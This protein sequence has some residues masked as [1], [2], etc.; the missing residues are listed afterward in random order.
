[1]RDAGSR[2]PDS[3]TDSPR[4]GQCGP[5]QL[6]RAA[7]H[8]AVSM[9]R[10]YTVPRHTGRSAANATSASNPAAH[11]RHGGQLRRGLRR[12]RGGRRSQRSSTG[13]SRCRSAA[14]AGTRPAPQGHGAAH[15]HAVHL[16]A[17][18]PNATS[19]P[20]PVHGGRQRGLVQGASGSAATSAGAR[21][22][23]QARVCAS[24]GAASSRAPLEPAAAQLPDSCS[25][26]SPGNTSLR[27]AQADA[28]ARQ[29]EPRAQ[30]AAGCR[31]PRSPPR[32]TG[33][34]PSAAAP[35]RHAAAAATRH[36]DRAGW[37]PAPHPAALAA[38]GAG[39]RRRGTGSPRWSAPDR[40]QPPARCPQP[41]CHRHS[42]AGGAPAAAA[43][44]PARA[45]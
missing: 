9:A 26:A 24:S 39:P 37:W 43:T 32:R 17:R 29:L 10:S 2:L 40:R 20:G 28:V 4:A 31:R 33:R 5:P 3:V 41:A 45:R 16:P 15:R 18:S 12:V 23:S 30:A 19:W 35:G 36:P 25:P 38:A 1:M 7:R 22:R 11:W 42:R 13:P 44:G 8:G 6:N 27:L 14:N 21:G 34:S